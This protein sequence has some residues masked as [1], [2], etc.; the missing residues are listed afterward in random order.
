M[1]IMN[2][3]EIAKYLRINEKK[4]YSL[5]QEGKLPHIKIGGKIGFPRELIDRWVL[6]HVEEERNIYIAGSDDPLLRLIIDVYNRENKNSTIFYAPVGSVRGLKILKEN[7]AKIACC[8]ILDMEKKGYSSSYVERYLGKGD[9]VLI[10][11]FKRE[12]GFYLSKGNP[13]GVRTFKD[14]ASKDVTF[15]NRNKD[16]GT[17]L[18]FDFL[19]KEEGINPQSIRGYE[20]EVDSHLQA[21][22]YVLKGFA[23]CA[24]GIRYITYVLDLDFIPIF[25]ERFDFVIPKE[26]YPKPHIKDLLS[27]FEQPRIFQLSKEL[28]GYELS[29]TGKI[30]RG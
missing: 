2:A 4:V 15:V 28:P 19:L 20:S 26:L 22:L 29:E 11:L 21:G 9:F 13:R 3:K 7:R 1:E 25:L 27:Y 8:H 16:S 5:V 6:E 10:E 30:L 17:R 14:I 23:D 24:F 12:Q 18:L